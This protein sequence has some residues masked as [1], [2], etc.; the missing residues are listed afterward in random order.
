[1]EPYIPGSITFPLYSGFTMYTSYIWCVINRDI[2]LPKI[3][4]KLNSCCT[5]PSLLDH[6][7]HACCGNEWCST[8]LM[9]DVLDK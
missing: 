6:T 8:D 9:K 7:Q 5:N 1:M 3:N 2:C 4:L